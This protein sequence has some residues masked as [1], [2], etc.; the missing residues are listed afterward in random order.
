MATPKQYSFG[1]KELAEMLVRE[2]GVRE[3]HW[4]LLI[5]FGLSA[6]NIGPSDDDLRPAA[7][8]PVMD[9]GIQQFDKPNSL[10]V[11]AAEV[12]KKTKSAPIP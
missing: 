8:V 9:V 4:G 7:I 3:G 2:A 5:R 12:Q 11:D 6:S 10:T 1:F